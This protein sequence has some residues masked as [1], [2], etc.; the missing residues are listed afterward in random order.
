MGKCVFKLT[1]I[2][3]KKN[4]RN[5]IF[6]TLETRAK[7]AKVHQYKIPLHRLLF[8]SFHSFLIY[9]FHLYSHSLEEE[10]KKD[11]LNINSE[12]GKK[13]FFICIALCNAVNS[14]IKVVL[15]QMVKS[16]IAWKTNGMLQKKMLAL[17][18]SSISN[19]FFL[20]LLLSDEN[21]NQ[22]RCVVQF[23][24]LLNTRRKKLCR[25]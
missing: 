1:K 17:K 6:L 5:S 20:L 9:F 21:E 16:A 4:R 8:F 7:M 25:A 14:G 18:V 19:I 3:T 2:G 12:R 10:A 23:V 11:D 24:C 13:N 22:I 15:T